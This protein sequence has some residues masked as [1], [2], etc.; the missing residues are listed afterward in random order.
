[1]AY[2]NHF[3]L[4]DDVSA[5]FDAAV[6]AAD[7]F[8]QSRYVG[9]YAVAS[10]A[11]LELA[12]KEVIVDFA[13]HHHSLFGSYLASRYEKINGRIGLSSIADE[14]LKPFGKDFQNRFKRLLKRV[15]GLSIKKR[16]YSVILSY[17]ALL[18]CRHEFAHEGSVPASTSY[19]DIKKGFEAGK[20]VMACFEKTLEKA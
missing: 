3:R 18:T 1:M 15:D 8:M 10:A 6:I 14:H 13:R 7:A 19:T 12:L 16:G 11:V 17:E 5:H 20:I 2:S 4:V 9:F